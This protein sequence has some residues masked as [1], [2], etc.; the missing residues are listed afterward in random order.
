MFFVFVVF[1][2]VVG[3]VGSSSTSVINPDDGLQEINP[4]DDLKVDPDVEPQIDAD[5]DDDNLKINPDDKIQKI[6]PYDELHID[7]DDDPDMSYKQGM[8]T[9]HNYELMNEHSSFG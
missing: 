2:F 9:I 7:P 6:N 5:D 3:V 8:F 1:V 4:D